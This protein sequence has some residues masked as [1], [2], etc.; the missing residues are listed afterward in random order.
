[1][2]EHCRLGSFLLPREEWQVGAREDWRYADM[3]RKLGR[4]GWAVVSFFAV[5]VVQHLMLV[6]LTMPLLAIH[7][8]PLPWQLL[9]DTA[10]FL[11]ALTG[12][13]VTDLGPSGSCKGAWNC[14]CART[15]H[16]GPGCVLQLPCTW[17]RHDIAA[18]SFFR[19]CGCHR[20]GQP[21]APLHGGE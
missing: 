16:V 4:A 18:L 20:C 6:G 1:M 11:A 3:R 12:G 10:I 8:S 7:T 13:A 14:A 19:H 17:L 5:G 2:P 15:S 21:A 9:A